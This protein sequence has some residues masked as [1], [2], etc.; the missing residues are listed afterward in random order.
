VG[1]VEDLIIVY[2]FVEG[3]ITVLIDSE[4]NAP[5]CTT[6]HCEFWSDRLKLCTHH[7]GVK[8]VYCHPLLTCA[9]NRWYS[10]QPGRNIE[11]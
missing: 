7:D 5:M 10:V 9:W 8:G 6:K 1:K 3:N 2:P 4:S 11:G